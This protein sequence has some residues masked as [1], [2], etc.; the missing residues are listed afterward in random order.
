M[1]GL[2]HS[3]DGTHL[4]Y[5]QK[6]LI[7]QGCRVYGVFLYQLERL[8]GLRQLVQ[9]AGVLHQLLRLY[10]FPYESHGLAI[11]SYRVLLIRRVQEYNPKFSQ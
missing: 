9:F 3:Y 7:V 2:V 5:L 10:H 4:A 6:H 1:L 11:G 8:L